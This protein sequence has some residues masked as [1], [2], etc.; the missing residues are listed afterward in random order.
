MEDKLTTTTV[1]ANDTSSAM[2]DIISQLGEDAV[3][4]STNHKDGKVH[5]TATTENASKTPRRMKPSQQFSKIFESRMLNDQFLTKEKPLELDNAFNETGASTAQLSALRNEI[6]DI[7]NML[8]GVVV[9]EPQNLNDN[10]ASTT[11]LKLRQCGF[12]PSIVKKLEKSFLGKDYESGRVSFLRSLAKTLVPSDIENLKEKQIFYIIGSS[13]SGRTTLSAKLAAF[14]ADNDKSNSIVLS[15]I[16]NGTGLM[17]DS[18]RGFARLLN[19]K[20][21]IVE[22]DKAPKNELDYQK[23]IIDVSLDL[24]HSMESIKA[25]RKIYGSK[26]VCII[27]AVPGGSSNRLIETLSKACEDIE[28]IIAL[29]KLDECEIGPEE[30]SKLAE[31]NSKIGIITGTND[32][33]NSLALSSENV[34]TQYLKENC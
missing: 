13:G 10:V 9:T 24:S 18:L 2:D 31:L 11:A 6:Q 12:S 1:I 22:K 30:F 19:L 20:T 23:T 8:S 17:S 29:S 7:R 34:L 15:E 21:S 32:I 33:V 14:L 16:Q 4:L 27:L 3:I 26:N 5:M 25:A 28:P